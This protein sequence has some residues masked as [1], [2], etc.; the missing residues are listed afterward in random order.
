MILRLLIVIT[1]SGILTAGCDEKGN[2]D[3]KANL[4]LLKAI[5]SMPA[6][7][8]VSMRSAP[9]YPER[10]PGGQ[11]PIGYTTSV[12]YRAPQRVTGGQVRAF[13]RS[14]LSAWTCVEQSSIAVLECRR[15]KAVLTVNTIS[16]ERKGRQFEIALDHDDRS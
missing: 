10:G 8:R 16:M 5:P 11:R 6:A 12:L 2:D 1:A 7:T 3:V 4:A 13:Y 9:Y 15:E 14:A